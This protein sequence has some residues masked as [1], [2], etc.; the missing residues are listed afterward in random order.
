MKTPEEI[1]KLLGVCCDGGV[2]E[3]LIAA[4]EVLSAY[5]ELY[6]RLQECQQ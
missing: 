1:L 5:E 6:D 3:S 2:A 4:R